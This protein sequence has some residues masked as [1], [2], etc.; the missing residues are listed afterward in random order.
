MSTKEINLTKAIEYTCSTIFEKIYYFE[1]DADDYADG[2]I[3]Q[4]GDN[5]KVKKNLI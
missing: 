2:V 3:N 5:D 1:E 4:F